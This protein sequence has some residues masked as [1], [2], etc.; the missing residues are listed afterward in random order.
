MKH[1]AGK[2]GEPQILTKQSSANESSM[3]K[4][5]CQKVP[6]DIFDLQVAWILRIFDG[7]LWV[8]IDHCCELHKD[9]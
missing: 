7:I 4:K 9:R 3:S 2:R 5:Q 8:H 1:N 6:K